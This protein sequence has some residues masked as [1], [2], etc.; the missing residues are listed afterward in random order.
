LMTS[1]FIDD[2]PISTIPRQRSTL[3]PHCPTD[4]LT[5]CPTALLYTTHRMPQ[6][7]LH[8]LRRGAQRVTQI[9]FVMAAAAR[10]AMLGGICIHARSSF[11]LGRVRTDVHALDARPFVEGL[12]PRA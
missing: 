3:L 2:L 6:D 11:R 12:Q 10:V 5:H 7:G 4:P 1:L 8:L 9:N